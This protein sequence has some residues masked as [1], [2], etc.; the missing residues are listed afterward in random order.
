MHPIDWLIMALPLAICLGIALYSRRYVR[1][2]ADFMAG[3]RHAGRYLI[4]TARAEQNSGAVSFVAIFQMFAVAGFTL[5]WWNLISVPVMMLV[6]VTGFVIYRYR[7]TRAMTLAQFFEMR[8]SKR[9]RIFAGLLGFLAGLVNFG[10]IPVV[11]ARFMVYFLGLP[12]ETDLFGWIVP[13]YLLL[14]GGFLS[15]CILTTTLGGQITILLT[16]CAEGMFSQVFYILIAI[17]LFFTFFNWADT[18]A[19]LLDTQPGH[20]LVN[21]FDSMGLTD[22]NLW[23]VAMALMLRIYGTMAWQNSHAFNSSAATPHDSRMGVVLGH[24][25]GF[26]ISAMITLLMICAL[27]YLHSPA[28]AAAVAA[29]LSG[30]TDPTVVNQMQ[31][32]LALSQILPIGVKGMLVAVIVMG[33]IAGDGIHLHSWSSIFIQDVVMPLRKKPLTPKQHIN[34]LRWSIVGVAAF[35]FLFGWLFPLIEYLSIW[36]SV[37]TAI[38]VG[39]AGAAIIGGLYWNRGTTAG[40]WAGLLV[41]STLSVGGI[42]IRLYWS[43]VLGQ[44]FFLNGVQIG[45]FASIIAVVTYVVVSWLTCKAPHDMDR[46]L[47]RGAHAAAGESAKPEERKVGWFHRLLGIDSDFSRS[48]RWITLGITYWSLFWCAVFVLGSLAYWIRPWSNEMWAD[49]WFVVSFCLP[50]VIAV[51]TTV[52]FTIGCWGDMRRFFRRLREERVDVSDDGSVRK[53]PH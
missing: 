20:S 16:D 36:W 2:V 24:W 49:Y 22:F 34:L 5:T 40:A 9:F 19:T 52:W 12:P 25:R 3:G 18:K 26:A 39:G 41:G 46:L 27:T 11:G 43:K 47:H 31:V 32:P 51:V 44:E 4:M 28:G 14:M 1:S 45:F 21:P 7:E 13:T 48:D 33:I 53:E 35:A 29:S 38:F 10:V 42:A 30:V 15:L 6:A 8:Y 37:T 23:F 17:V 50:M